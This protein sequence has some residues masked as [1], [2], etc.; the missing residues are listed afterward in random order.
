MNRLQQALAKT[1]NLSSARSDAD[2]LLSLLKKSLHHRHSFQI[3]VRLH[4]PFSSYISN[5]FVVLRNDSHQY[6]LFHSM[7]ALEI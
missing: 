3:T 5:F 2:F 7:L 1:P 6:R 4:H